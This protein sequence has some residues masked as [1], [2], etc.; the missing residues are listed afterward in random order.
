MLGHSCERARRYRQ[1]KI[2]NLMFKPLVSLPEHIDQLRG[3]S[4]RDDPSESQ[5]S[6]AEAMVHDQPLI[7]CM[8]TI[9]ACDFETVPLTIRSCVRS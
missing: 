4:R 8:A 9:T 3:V 6:A 7:R 1:F 5:G 2:L